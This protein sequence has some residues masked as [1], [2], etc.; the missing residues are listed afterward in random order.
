MVAAEEAAKEATASGIPAEE[1]HVP[2]A[3]LADLSEEEL[4]AE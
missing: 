3:E 2:S 4:E 1:A